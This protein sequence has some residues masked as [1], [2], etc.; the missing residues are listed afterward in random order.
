MGETDAGGAEEIVVGK[1]TSDQAMR[2][3]GFTGE[4][5]MSSFSLYI[6]GFAVFICGLAY[7]AFL[8]GAPQ[9]YIV[10]GVIIL[11]GFGIMSAARSTRTRDISP[12]GAVDETTTTT[13][14]KDV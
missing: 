3:F 2:L 14:R 13:T 7:G 8:L 10:V 9:T 6:F 1:G 4:S 11:A 5:S 12:D